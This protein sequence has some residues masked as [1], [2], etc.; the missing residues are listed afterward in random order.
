[1]SEK[2]IGRSQ[3]GCNDCDG[4]RITEEVVEEVKSVVGWKIESHRVAGV[5]NAQ[6]SHDVF[7]VRRLDPGRMGS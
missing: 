7:K 1:M 4:A 5:E 3:T 6:S 2:A